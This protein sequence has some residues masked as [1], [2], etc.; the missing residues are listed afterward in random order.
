MMIFLLKDIENILRHELELKW[1]K[2]LQTPHPLGY[3]DN[4]YHKG[5]I[6]GLP[7]VDVCSFKSICKTNY[8]ISW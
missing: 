1:I 8:T 5:N 4:I 3:K 2:L 6:S 7:D